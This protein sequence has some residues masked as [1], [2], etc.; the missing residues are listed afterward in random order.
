MGVYNAN[1][2]PD[3]LTPHIDEEAIRSFDGPQVFFNG[4]ACCR[5]RSQEWQFSRIDEN[6][7]FTVLRILDVVTPLMD[8]IVVAAP[9]DRPSQI[10][11]KFLS[12]HHVDPP[13]RLRRPYANWPSKAKMTP[14][15]L[16]MTRLVRMMGGN[17]S[18]MVAHGKWAL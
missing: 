10:D 18:A 6:E 13:H 16:L 4:L 17:I 3:R 9:A 1:G 8:L 15:S 11:M 2:R 7:V 14:V 12:L 5:A